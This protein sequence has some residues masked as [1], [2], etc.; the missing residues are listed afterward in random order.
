MDFFWRPHMAV[1]FG[2]FPANFRFSGALLGLQATLIQ[3]G[4]QPVEGT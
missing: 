4:G 3:G 1:T 2:Q